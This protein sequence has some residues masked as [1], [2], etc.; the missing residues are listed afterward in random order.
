MTLHAGANSAVQKVLDDL[1]ADG[2]EIGVQVAA[3][4]KGEMIVDAWAGMADP[5]T[6]RPVDGDTLFNVFS[7]TKAV[8]ATALHLQAERGLVDYDSPVARY[9]PE[10]GAQG[11]CRIAPARRK[12]PPVSHRCRS[13]TGM[14]PPPASL[15]W[16]LCSPWDNPPTRLSRSAG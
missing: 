12:C 7:V 2:R 10:Y 13:A 5:G 3:Y 4:L 9:W 6:G 1:V 11:R 16:S 8:A 15:R 14:P